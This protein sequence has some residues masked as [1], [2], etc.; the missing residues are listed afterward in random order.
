MLST[1]DRKLGFKIQDLHLVIHSNYIL[2][3]WGVI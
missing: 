2:I 3:L 1:A